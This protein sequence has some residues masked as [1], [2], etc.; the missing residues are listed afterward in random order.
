MRGCSSYCNGEN[1]ITFSS[2]NTVILGWIMD[3]TI[4]SLQFICNRISLS[5]ILSTCYFIMTCEF[6]HYVYTI[7]SPLPSTKATV[8]LTN[9]NILFT[10]P[11]DILS[12]AFFGSISAHNDKR[13]I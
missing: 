2:Q 13:S 12:P 1:K 9:P 6:L 3:D 7:T 5:C 4:T 10:F 11:L 8:Q